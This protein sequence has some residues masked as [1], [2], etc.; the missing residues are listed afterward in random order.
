MKYLAL[1]VS[2]GV[3]LASGAALAADAEQLLKDKACLAC[4]QVDKKVVG[5]AYKDVAAKY[6]ERKDAEAYLASK[7]KGGSTGV[8]GPIPMP[9]NAGVNDE[10]AKT[11]AKFVMT[12]K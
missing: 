11:L 2:L 10:E 4:H 9:P 12:L 3:A 7:I 6:K 8:W 1:S 5:P